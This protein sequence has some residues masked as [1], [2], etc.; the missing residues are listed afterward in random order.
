MT[1]LCSFIR[2]GSTSTSLPRVSADSV[3]GI[4]TG[5]TIGV[6][7]G[8]IIGVAVGVATGITKGVATVFGEISREK[9][10][11]LLV[12]LLVPT[13]LSVLGSVS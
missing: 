10:L 7:T 2:T 13:M 4:T 3:A 9:I 1:S 5:M 12:I 6:A 8:V 11:P